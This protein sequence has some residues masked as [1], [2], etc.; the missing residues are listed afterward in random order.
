MKVSVIVPVYNVE[1]YLPKCLETLANQTL[2]DIEVLIINDGS[3][4]NSQKIID[5]FVKK[6]PKIFK[7][8]T[9]EN[10]GLS[11]ARNYGIEKAKGEYI[12]FLDSDDYVEHDIYEKLLN[13][14]MEKDFDIVVCDCTY[15]YDDYTV[16]ASSNIKNDIFTDKEL[17]KAMTNIYPVAWNKLYKREVIADLRFKKGVWFEDIEYL[18]RIYP[19]IKSIGVV[20]E[21]LINYL[22]RLNAITKTFDERLYHYIDNMNGVI[23]YYK[24]NNL[25]DEYEREL[26]YIYVRYLYATFVKQ[27]TNY[28]DYNEYKIA[29][30]EA[31]KNVKLHMPK[32]RR[33]KYF[34]RNGLKGIYLLLFNKRLAK[35][36][37][38]TK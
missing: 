29:V 21:P 24:E 8:F 1:E 30:D 38:K 12:A 4:D 37:F 14:A 18:L 27:A 23:E 28:P 3:P 13:K 32:Y 20:N 11:D 9:K 15:V 19:N 36:L 31:I 34:Y 7:S 35:L 10:G 22:Q 25:Y 5:K 17:K 2:K 16:R 6:Y 33:N 26:E